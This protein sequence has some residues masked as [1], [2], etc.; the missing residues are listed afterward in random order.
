MSGVQGNSV[1]LAMVEQT[2]VDSGVPATP[3]WDVIPR[4]GGDVDDAIGT[5]SSNL[6]DTTRQGPRPVLT[7]IDIA[8]NIPSEL[9][10]TE[11]VFQN[12]VKGALQNPI[13]TD[14]NYAASTISFDNGTSEIRDSALGFA[15]IDVGEYFGVFGATT[16]ANNQVYLVTAKADNG[17]L[18]VSPTPTTEAAGASITLKGKQVRS[19]NSE[20]AYSVQKRIPGSDGTVYYTFEGLQVSSLAL[21]ITPQSLITTTVDMVGLQKLDGTS[22]IAGSTDNAESTDRVTGTVS[23]VP[24]IFIDSVNQDPSDVLATDLSFTIDNGSSGT[25]VVGSAGASCILHNAINV[26]GTLN[27]YV[28]DTVAE[29]TAEKVKATNQTEFQLALVFKD[30]DGNYVVFDFPAVQYTTL[31]N[32]DTANGDLL[33]NTGTFQAHGKGTSGY[34]VGVTFVEAP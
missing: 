14:I 28:G 9:Q 26:T 4:T 32:P 29:I 22:Q 6:V 23:G 34:T 10:V 3:T 17:T 16:A 5:T 1:V 13:G 12:F 15:A 27:T 24:Q 25:P 11:T 20:I 31:T 21:S 18:T 19:G 2:A 30:A 33:T 8:S 7:S